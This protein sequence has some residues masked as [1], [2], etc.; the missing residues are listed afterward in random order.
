MSDAIFLHRK[1]IIAK[2]DIEECSKEGSRL[3]KVPTIVVRALSLL[4][5]EEAR[6]LANMIHKVVDVAEFG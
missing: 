4:T 6:T 3:D 2:V 5:W 1:S